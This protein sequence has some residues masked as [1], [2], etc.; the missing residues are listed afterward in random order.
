MQATQVRQPFHREPW[1]YEER[2][3]GWRML[4]DKT[5]EPPMQPVARRPRSDMSSAPTTAVECMRPAIWQSRAMSA[6]DSPASRQ[7]SFSG[8]RWKLDVQAAGI[9]ARDVRREHPPAVG[10]ETHERV[11]KP[12][13]VGWSEAGEAPA[14]LGAERV[15]R[16]RHDLGGARFAELRAECLEE[17][18]IQQR[19]IPERRVQIESQLI[20]RSDGA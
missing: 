10:H 13:E 14:D 19:A 17:P 6:S 7:A 9:A 2:I 18:V 4:A 20:F 5:V 8:H 15:D 12:R 3:D 1:V 16:P 11:S